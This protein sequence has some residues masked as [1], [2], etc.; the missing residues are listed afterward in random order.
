MT[1]PNRKR[2]IRIRPTGPHDADAILRIARELVEDGATYS[3]A[4]G[5]SD[6]ELL[7]YW[8]APRER[9]FVA[10]LDGEIAGCYV[11]RPN[12]PG[13]ASHVA[14]CSYAVAARQWGR[15]VGQAMA[16][17]SLE[18]ARRSGFQAMQF[19]FVVATNERALA[20]WQRLGFR[21]VGT[22]PQ[23]FDHPRLGLVDAY[24]MH[25]FL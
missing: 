15:G 25:R 21:I 8:L 24:V 6:E 18:E 14:N 5:T 9:T 2:E 23:A 20:L 12:H 11:L 22:S 17:H 16:E 3:F 1:E 4:P 13:R 19:N 10:L 7:A